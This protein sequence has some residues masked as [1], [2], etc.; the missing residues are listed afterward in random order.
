MFF[1][2]VLYYNYY[3]FHFK[4][5]KDPEPFAMT[6]FMLSFTESFII[7]GTIDLINVMKFCKPTERWVAYPLMALLV[8]INYLIFNSSLRSRRIIKEKPSLW[9]RPRL[10][11]VIT[12]AFFCLSLFFL[13]VVMIFTKKQLEDCVLHN[14]LDMH[15]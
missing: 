4:I 8:G 9:N 7:F 2:D 14:L 15:Q 10:S 12:V 1:F 11:A 13:I 5:M 6:S 3:L